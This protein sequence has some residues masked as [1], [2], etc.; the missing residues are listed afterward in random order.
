M[1][2]VYRVLKPGGV[3]IIISFGEPAARLGYLK[4][5]SLDWKVEHKEIGK[6]I[7]ALPQADWKPCVETAKPPL[8]GFKEVG[9]SKVHHMYVCQKPEQGAGGSGAGAGAGAGATQYEDQ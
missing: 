8:E 1:Q 4:G 9:V 6:H 5:K 3:Y 7:A 2:E